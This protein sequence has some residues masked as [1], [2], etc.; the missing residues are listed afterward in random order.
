MPSTDAH[1]EEAGRRL[2]QLVGLI[3]HEAV[4]TRQD[5][6]EPLILERQVGTEEMVIHDHKVRGLGL[7]TRGD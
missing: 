5:L 4:R 6:A 7:A 1:A 2:G 3:E